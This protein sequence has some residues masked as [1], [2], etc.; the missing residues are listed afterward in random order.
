MGEAIGARG[1]SATV[2]VAS[3]SGRVRPAYSASACVLVYAGGQIRDGVEESALGVDRFVNTA[4]I[5]DPVAGA[6]LG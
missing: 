5:S 3:A 1:L 2:G 4:A 6:V